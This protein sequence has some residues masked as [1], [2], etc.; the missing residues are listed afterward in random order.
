MKIAIVEFN[1]SHIEL[2]PSYYELLHPRFHIAFF[3][4]E[5]VPAD[6]TSDFSGVSFS[7]IKR[8]KIKLID[9][10]LLSRCLKKQGFTHCILNT[11]EGKL[12]RALCFFNSWHLIRNLGVIHNSEKMTKPGFTQASILKHLKYKLVL[13]DFIKKNFPDPTVQVFY[14]SFQFFK[15]KRAEASNKK[16]IISVIGNIE[17][18]RRDYGLLVNLCQ[19]YKEELKNKILIKIIG[20]SNA[21]EGPIMLEQIKEAGIEDFFQCYNHRLSS[22][23]LDY[24]LINSDLILP[25]ITPHIKIFKDYLEYKISGAYNLSYASHI[26]MIIHDRFE[27][28]DDF[29]HGNYFFSDL[30]DLFNLLIKLFNNRQ[31]I[32][33]K[34]EL[35]K[36][37]TEFL[38]KRQ[39][40][41]FDRILSK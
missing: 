15:V 17:F 36:E 41:I 33:V 34:S 29:N 12:P 35:V 39:I 2:L 37:R 14:P 32:A 24:E 20:N 13:S 27:A 25:L 8:T 4:N 7:I 26:P 31:D 1:Y 19:K 16:L 40:E 21:K 11:A 23:E 18:K 22:E 5:K 6:F 10:Y 30:N 28:M 3:V 38:K 9:A